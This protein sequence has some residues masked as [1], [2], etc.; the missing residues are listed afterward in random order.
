LT[1][2]HHDLIDLHTLDGIV[3]YLNRNSAER[4]ELVTLVEKKVKY[5]KEPRYI[6][7]VKRPID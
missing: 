3:D 1:E 2:W 4:W 6:A 5:S 7:V